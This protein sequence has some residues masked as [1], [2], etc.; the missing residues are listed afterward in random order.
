L[1]RSLGNLLIQGVSAYVG[2]Q[3]GKQGAVGLV[4]SYFI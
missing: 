4:T 3:A 2:Q 1:F